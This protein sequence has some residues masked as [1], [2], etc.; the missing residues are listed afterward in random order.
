MWPYKVVHTL[1]L[2]CAQNPR[3]YQAITPIF[4]KLGKLCRLE[5][6]YSHQDPLLIM[7]MKDYISELKDQDLDSCEKNILQFISHC[8][9]QVAYIIGVCLKT[10]HVF[11]F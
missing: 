10:K 9:Y 7:A 8:L 4:H 6:K 1:F 2:A 5:A 3:H 11:G